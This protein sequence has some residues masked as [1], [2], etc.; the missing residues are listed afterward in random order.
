MTRLQSTPKWSANRLGLMDRPH[1]F[2][3]FTP[4]TEAEVVSDDFD[5]RSPRITSS[6]PAVY[7]EPDRT[8]VVEQDWPI[9]QNLNPFSNRKGRLSS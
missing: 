2:T 5:S 9:D 8:S 7:Y 1:R 3:V 4:W 6:D